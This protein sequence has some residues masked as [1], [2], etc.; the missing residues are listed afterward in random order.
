MRDDRL[1]RFDQAR[2]HFRRA[3]ACARQH[4][5]LARTAMHLYGDHG[6]VISGCVR[7][8]FPERVK[9]R[10]C[11]LARS[12]TEHTDAGYA[13]RPPR[14]RRSTMRAL[15]SD[16]ARREGGGYYGPRV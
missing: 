9:K 12:A 2:E 7:D 13:A 14:A 1:T 3:C 15:A 16:V 10:L 5:I 6:P 4:A 11:D 8:H